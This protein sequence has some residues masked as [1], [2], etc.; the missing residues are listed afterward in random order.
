MYAFVGLGFVVCLAW[1]SAQDARDTAR[2]V[3]QDDAF[4]TE[5]PVGEPPASS[6]GSSGRP[7]PFNWSSERR[8]DLPPSG[9]GSL[10]S[11][12][13]WI[14][15]GLVIGALLLVF[16]REAI[17]G[18]QGAVEDPDGLWAPTVH[19]D[20]TAL[21]DAEQL[22]REGRYV[23]AI[24]VLLLRTFEAIGRR[25]RLSTALTSREVLSAVEMSQAAHGALSDLVAAVEIS[26]F[27][28]Q[29]VGQDDYLRCVE[30]YR[31]VLAAVGVSA[32]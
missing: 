21:G 24:R 5:L 25:A 19:V 1:P 20:A 9:T 4:Q 32:S 2:D 23:E 13:V 6:S 18:R 22:A 29:D 11:T 10:V 30:R 15:L 27:G 14:V 12:I 16:V 28:G 31:A 26:H 17:A 7:P 8:V 3:L